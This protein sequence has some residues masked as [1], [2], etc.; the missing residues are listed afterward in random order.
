MWNTFGIEL[1]KKQKIK[2]G[3]FQAWDTFLLARLVGNLKGSQVHL[4]V[5]LSDSFTKYSPNLRSCLRIY[6]K[7]STCLHQVR[8]LMVLLDDEGQDNQEVVALIPHREENDIDMR[9][10]V[11]EM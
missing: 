9:I 7:F 2:A 3:S 1:S 4:I 6:L 11:S 10:A 5:Y 8:Q